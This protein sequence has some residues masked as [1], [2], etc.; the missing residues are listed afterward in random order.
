MVDYNF[1]LESAHPAAE[2]YSG[3]K[4]GFYGNNHFKIVNNV[5]LKKNLTQ[6][7]W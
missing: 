3:G 2:T 4:A 5:L 1:I 7:N 6:I